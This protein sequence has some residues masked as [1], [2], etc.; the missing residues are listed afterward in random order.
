MRKD[1]NAEPRLQWT[2]IFVHE[3][4]QDDSDEREEAK[5]DVDH[6]IFSRAM[7]HPTMNPSAHSERSRQDTNDSPSEQRPDRH[8]S[9]IGEQ[10]KTFHRHIHVHV[11]KKGG[12][13]PAMDALVKATVWNHMG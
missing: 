6:F 1:H 2:R 12:I 11:T 9:T 4:D 8:G 7:H 13:S 10:V 3:S 5:N